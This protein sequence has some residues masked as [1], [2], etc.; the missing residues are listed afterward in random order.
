MNHN[1]IKTYSIYVYSF[2]DGKHYVGRSTIFA[3]RCSAS[4]YKQNEELYK[5]L[6]TESYDLSIIAYAFNLEDARELENY[7]IHKYDSIRN[8]YNKILNKFSKVS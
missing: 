6:K 7:Y 1:N 8:G 2:A 4:H 5:A 3:K